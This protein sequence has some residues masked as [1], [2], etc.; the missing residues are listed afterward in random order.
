MSD[1]TPA[2]QTPLHASWSMAEER[3]SMAEIL[4]EVTHERLTGAAGMQ[5]L[6]QDEIR[7]LFKAATPSP[8]SDGQD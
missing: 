5:K 1:E 6:K 7:R 8:D 4:K 3:Y 2:P